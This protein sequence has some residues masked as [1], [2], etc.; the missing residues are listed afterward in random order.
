MNVLR[1]LPAAATST[2]AALRLAA[3]TTCR[4]SAVVR[5]YATERASYVPPGEDEEFAGIVDTVFHPSSP[6]FYTGRSQFYD[7]HAELQ[8][9]VH[10]VNAGLRQLHLFPLPSFA[11]ASLPALQPY[12]LPHAD[13][14]NAFEAKLTISRYRQIVGLLN[15]LDRYRS[16]AEVSGHGEYADR[17]ADLLALYESPNKSQKLRQKGGKKSKFDEWGRS[18]TLGKRKESAARVWMI[19]VQ[20]HLRSGAAVQHA[21]NAL[22]NE[23]HGTLDAETEADF[24][25]SGAKGA[26]EA[27]ATL[28]AEV[29]FPSRSPSV[30]LKA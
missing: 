24:V 6:T 11:L 28:N 21:V 26:L 30:V 27:E 8:R 10:L 19:P 16:I 9:A 13:M 22:E 3:A 29:R 18:Y 2:S 7:Q 25:A 14:A 17:I 23:E 15:E 12:W 5:T 1:Q 20:Q 4:R